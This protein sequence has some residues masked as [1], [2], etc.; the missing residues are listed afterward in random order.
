MLAVFPQKLTIDQLYKYEVTDV[1]SGGM[2]YVFLLSL[3]DKVHQLHL[4]ERMLQRSS[5]LALRFR[6]PYRPTLAAKTVRE[7]E[8]MPS[9]ARECNI[10]LEFEQPGIVPLLKVID[11]AG[12]ILAYTQLEEVV[13]RAAIAFPIRGWM[14]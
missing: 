8:L 10:W 14:G 5:D 6:Y 4:M 3:I 2:G 13:R 9:F 1:L 12:T 11:V 7:S